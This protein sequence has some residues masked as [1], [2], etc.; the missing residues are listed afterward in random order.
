MFW[1]LRKVGSRWWL[2]DSAGN[3]TRTI[4]LNSV[5]TDPKADDWSL[6]YSSKGE[7]HDAI[8]RMMD[9]A[10]MNTVGAFGNEDIPGVAKTPLLSFLGGYASDQNIDPKSAN[11]RRLIS[12]PGFTDFCMERARQKC[13]PDNENLIGYFF[14]NELNWTGA[15][16]ATIRSYMQ[17]CRDAIQAFDTHHL[18]FGPRIHRPS[19][20]N[21]RLFKVAGQYCDALAINYYGVNKP[22]LV[23]TKKWSDWAGG[24]PYIVTEFYAMAK[25]GCVDGF[26]PSNN[27]GAG[28]HV[29]TQSER[30]AWFKG[31]AER[32][33]SDPRCIGYHW[34]R[35]Q[36]EPDDGGSNK[37]VVGIKFT[38]YAQLLQQMAN[39]NP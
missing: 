28:A 18:L 21:E 20:D 36:D 33:I 38:L 31:F 9:D 25:R 30:A 13:E 3:N 11:A 16:A 37:G 2:V 19:F 26:R 23:Q 29:S 4:G 22:V 1:T 10:G 35:Y 5:D 14:D 24:K 32:A 7:W 17:K 34:F 8:K 12:K 15:S 27:K 6:H 39:T